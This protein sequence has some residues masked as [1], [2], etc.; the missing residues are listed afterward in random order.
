VYRNTI[1]GRVIR[2][3]T[4]PLPGKLLLR[5]FRK[6]VASKGLTRDFTELMPGKE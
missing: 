4:K 3:F 1:E 5:E 2:K 6:I